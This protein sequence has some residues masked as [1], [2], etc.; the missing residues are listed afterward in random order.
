MVYGTDGHIKVKPY[1]PYNIDGTGYIDTGITISGTN[2]GYISETKMTEYGE[3]P[4]KVSGSETTYVPD[5]FWFNTSQLNFLIWGASCNNGLHVGAA[6]FAVNN[7]FSYSYW[8]LGPSLSYKQP[9][10][11]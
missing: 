10:A 6:C 4:V 5:G 7:L 2:G 1:P 3:F 11:A 8:D 9:A